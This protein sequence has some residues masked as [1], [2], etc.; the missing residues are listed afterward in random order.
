MRYIREINQGVES[1][2]ATDRVIAAVVAPLESRPAINYILGGLFDDQYQS[3]LQQKKFFRATTIKAR[4]N[5]IH[6]EGRH[7]ETKPI[8]IPISFPPFNLNS[9]IMPTMMH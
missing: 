9:I 8:D 6:T 5:A 2:Q 1:R 4:I 3:K 7:E